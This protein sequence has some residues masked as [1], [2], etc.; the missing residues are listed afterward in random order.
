MNTPPSQTHSYGRT[1]AF[2]TPFPPSGSPPPLLQSTRQR[3]YAPTQNEDMIG[4]GNPVT[5]PHLPRQRKTTP[6]STPKKRINP[7]QLLWCPFHQTYEEHVCMRPVARKLE[8]EREVLPPT[9]PPININLNI[10]MQ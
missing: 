10:F 9:P 8:W 1:S 7:T 3:R 2:T 5:P 4:G 6:P